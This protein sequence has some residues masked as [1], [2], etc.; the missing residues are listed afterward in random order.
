MRQ[1]PSVETSG[2][3]V[4]AEACTSSKDKVQN[5]SITWSRCEGSQVSVAWCKHEKRLWS[6]QGNNWN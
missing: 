2:H 4:K 3:I 6:N 1:E 5:H